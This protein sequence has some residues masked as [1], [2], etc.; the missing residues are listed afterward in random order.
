MSSIGAASIGGLN[1][2]GS[3]AGTQR[4]GVDNKSVT[5]NAANQ[6]AASD[7]A[8]QSARALGDVSE[9]DLS[10]DRDADGRQPYGRLS[11]PA[12][13]TGHDQASESDKR[14]R[15]S[16]ALGERGNSLDLQA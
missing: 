12:E 11:R 9:A 7:R 10:S 5:Q 3:V 4:G 15:I 14:H 13:D 8:D 16:D 6:K 2:A 1:L